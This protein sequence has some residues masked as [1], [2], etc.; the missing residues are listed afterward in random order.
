MHIFTDIEIF[1]KINKFV[2]QME[3]L[4]ESWEYLKPFSSTYE[5]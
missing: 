4:G 3:N 2:S 5:V 1:K